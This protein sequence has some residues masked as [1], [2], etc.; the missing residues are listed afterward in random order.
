M[1]FKFVKFIR[2]S[3]LRRAFSLIHEAFKAGQAPQ[4]HWGQDGED[5]FLADTLPSAGFY[6]DVGAHHPY[7]R[8]ST[9]LLYDKG[10]QGINIDVTD[11]METLFPKYRPRD[12][13]HF[14]LVGHP[15]KARF[16]RFLEPALSTLDPEL[17][18]EREREGWPILREDILEVR[19]LDSIL[20]EL[21]APKRIDLLC[22][23]V[24]GSD[25]EVLETIS[26][27]DRVV[28]RVLVELHMP[29]WQLSTHPISKFLEAKGYRPVAVWLRSTLFELAHD[30]R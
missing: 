7:R 22:V 6:V 23:D 18:R 16:F 12:V 2:P 13:N 15:R 8:S 4:V 25:F 28:S 24:E 5:V 10:W 29:A 21:R 20:D 30:H 26:L 19:P 14:G 3:T 17:A 27:A 1:V 11:A 9:K